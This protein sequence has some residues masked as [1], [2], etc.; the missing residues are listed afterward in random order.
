MKKIII[1]AAIAVS[2]L[3]A[4]KK[5]TNSNSICTSAKVTYGGDPAADGLGW[6]LVTDT[7][8]NSYKYEAPENLP[9]EFKTNGKWVDVCYFYTANDF[10]CFC[11]P[12]YQKT[13][14]I[15]S[16]KAW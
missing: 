7:S 10:V 13:V 4:C 3:S 1:V 15:V 16:I 14:H 12:P 2:L 11:A 6:I 9:G 8:A 5:D